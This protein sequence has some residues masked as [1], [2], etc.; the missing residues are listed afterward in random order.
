MISGFGRCAL[1]GTLAAIL[2]GC[3]APPSAVAPPSTVTPMDALRIATRAP[4]PDRAPS[5]MAPEASHQN[6]LYL[7]DVG[8]DDVY[9]YSYPKGTL[10]GTL[11]GFA[12]PLRECSD[13]DGDVFITNTGDKD[14][15]EYRH[16]DKSPVAT[17]RDHGQI[18]VD[19]AIDP[20]SGNLAVTNYGPTGYNVGSVSIYKHAR[21]VAK[22]YK[23]PQLIAYLFCAYDNAG[24][25]FVNAL[26]FNYDYVF[27]ELP[28]GA[29]KFER[30]RLDHSFIGWGSVQWDGKYVAIGDGATTVYRFV[31]KQNKA[32]EAGVIHLRRATNV[33]QFWIQGR[34]VIGP[35]GPD[36]G[37]K[38]VGFW[39][40]PRGGDATQTLSGPFENPSGATVSQASGAQRR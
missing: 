22:I 40:Y 8:T 27:V 14:I 18:P 29:T 34:T 30:I 12:N 25:L 6:L 19:C 5:W 35:D 38:D 21:G 33:V 20:G 9:V 32:R 16:G 28:K 15:L 4:H 36:G 24:N 1:G 2:A 17:L 7:S 26:N 31:V 37:N 39:N 23:D 13:Q 3:A 11:T 10:V